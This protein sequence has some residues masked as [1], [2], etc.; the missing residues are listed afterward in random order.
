MRRHAFTLIELLIVIGIIVVL[1][2]LL[3]PAIHSAYM[4]AERSRMR[5]DLQ[6]IANA[7]DAYRNDFGDYPRPGGTIYSSRLANGAMQIGG[8]QILCWALVAPG[9]AAEDGAD[10]PGFRLRGATGRVYGPYLPPDRFIIGTF[11]G[12]PGDAALVT[13]YSQSG[14]A[15]DDWFAVLADRRGRRI[16]YYPAHRNARPGT[17]PGSYVTAAGLPRTAQN[18]LWDAND[19]DPVLLPDWLLRN[20]LGATRHGVVAEGRSAVIAPYLLISAG[21]AAPAPVGANMTQAIPDPFGREG[22]VANVDLEML[23]PD[24]DP[25]RS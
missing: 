7:I 25:S 18:P 19:G 9:P 13:S 12:A 20:M 4:A 16:L 2:A 22:N 17:T 15:P 23:R 8:A 10:G 3:M 5:A 1:A 11:T 6:V 14:L 24:P 21:T